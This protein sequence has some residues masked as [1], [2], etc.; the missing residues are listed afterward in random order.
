MIDTHLPET[1]S[2]YSIIRDYAM[3]TWQED[4]EEAVNFYLRT[5]R[6]DR[7]LF[8]G[9]ADPFYDAALSFVESQVGQ[10]GNQR[11]VIHNDDL[12]CFVDEGRVQ[13]F[14]NFELSRLGTEQMQLARVIRWCTRDG[15]RWTDVLSGYHEETG[16]GV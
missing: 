13:G 12:L 8:P 14:Y 6:R 10:F 9:A 5:C 1:N 11:R 3:I 4:L 7:E 15:L 16:R 2:G